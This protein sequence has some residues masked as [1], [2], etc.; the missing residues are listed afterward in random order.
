MLMKE[1]NER[2][3][4]GGIAWRQSKQEGGILSHVGE[5]LADVDD[6][7]NSQVSRIGCFSKKRRGCERAGNDVP[8][9]IVVK[10]ASA[11]GSHFGKVSV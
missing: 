7:P 11:D 9:V 8:L 6:L 1:R 2:L 10:Y 4:F 3:L 5:K